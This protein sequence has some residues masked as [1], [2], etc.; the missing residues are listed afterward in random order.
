MS[1]TG[2]VKVKYSSMSKGVFRN[3]SCSYS[4]S[5]CKAALFSL[6]PCKISLV[7]FTFSWSLFYKYNAW[8]SSLFISSIKSF[9][10]LFLGSYWR[11]LF[12]DSFWAYKNYYRFCWA[13]FFSSLLAY[14]FAFSSAKVSSC[15]FV[16]SCCYLIFAYSAFICLSTYSLTR[17]SLAL[18][19]RSRGYLNGM[20]KA[21]VLSLLVILLS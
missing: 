18:I 4:Y 5:F 15:L 19:K 13:A 2:G 6:L 12:K 11:A 16:L 7:L 14:S 3:I 20:R 21:P 17:W 1:W 9:S 10:Y 8:I